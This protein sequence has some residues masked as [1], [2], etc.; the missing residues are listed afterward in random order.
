MI[1]PEKGYQKSNLFLLKYEKVI[2]SK[3]N[4]TYQADADF[5]SIICL[6]KWIKTEFV[7]LKSMSALIN[8]TVHFKC[9]ISVAAQQFVWFLGT[10]QE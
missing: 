10:N 4:F 8:S 2:K 9:C 6:S 1:R 7:D 5:S 3:V